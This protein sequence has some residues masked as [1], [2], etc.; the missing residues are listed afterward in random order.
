MSTPDTSEESLKKEIEQLK[1]AIRAKRKKL[2]TRK[3][4]KK[5]GR[6]P[7]QTGIKWVNNRY[8]VERVVEELEDDQVRTEIIGDF[9]KLQDIADHLGKAYRTIQRA[10]K[11]TNTLSDTLIITLIN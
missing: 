5:R 11:Q 2:N 10:F 8:H 3:P 7:G 6:K 1:Y 4:L 9:V